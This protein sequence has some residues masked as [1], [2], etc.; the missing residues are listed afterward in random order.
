MFVIS[1]VLSYLVP[2]MVCGF[3][4]F[5]SRSKVTAG[6][7]MKVAVACLSSDDL[8]RL[9]VCK[10]KYLIRPPD[11][12]VGGLRFTAFLSFLLSFFRQLP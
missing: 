3:S 8:H 11:I 5:M 4:Q 7:G 1:A 6:S 9:S 2:L 10:R 12:V